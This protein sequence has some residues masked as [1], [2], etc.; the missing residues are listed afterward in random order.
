[1]KPHFSGYLR[2][3]VSV[4]LVHCFPFVLFFVFLFFFF[5][6]LFFLFSFLLG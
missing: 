2:V 5:S 1:M 6:F 3:S 4:L